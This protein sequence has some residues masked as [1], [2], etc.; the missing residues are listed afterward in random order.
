MWKRCKEKLL[1]AWKLIGHIDLFFTST[2]F[3][4]S[5]FTGGFMGTIS[6]I[7]G[8]QIPLILMFGV[9]A[10]GLG[11]TIYNQ[12]LWNKNYLQFTKKIQT[13]NEFQISVQ[14]DKPH[15]FQSAENEYIWY[16][17]FDRAIFVNKNRDHRL[18]VDSSIKFYGNRHAISQPL[19]EWEKRKGTVD[20][21]P[22]LPMPI[23]LEPD[24]FQHGYLAFPLTL[25]GLLG[26]FSPKAI[27]IAPMVLSLILKDLRSGK[28]KPVEVYK[29]SLTFTPTSGG[30]I[31]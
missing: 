18:L 21:Q 2:R 22:H 9:G 19:L 29:G 20:P 7:W 5:L 4:M 28:T 13:Y 16:I 25:S 1:E 23:T 31:K 14:V 30:W 12:Y 8:Y 17:V 27:V 26:G 24:S 15:I 11:L 3:V 6:W 10:F